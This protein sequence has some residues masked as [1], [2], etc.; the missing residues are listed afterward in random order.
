MEI[1]SGNPLQK[2]LKTEFAIPKLWCSS[3]VT[4]FSAARKNDSVMLWTVYWV[5]RHKDEIC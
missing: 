4:I 2:F 5:S 1:F 3:K